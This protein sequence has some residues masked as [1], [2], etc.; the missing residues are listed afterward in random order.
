MARKQCWERSKLNT[1]GEF[2]KNEGFRSY[3]QRKGQ[4]EGN[5]TESSKIL[6]SMD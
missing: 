2:V 4:K 5:R 3:R 6:T 1:T